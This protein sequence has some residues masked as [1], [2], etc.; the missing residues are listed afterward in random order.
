MKRHY[1]REISNRLKAMVND[2]RI[3]IHKKMFSRN[4]P[5]MK[6][7]GQIGLE[8]VYEQLG[9]DANLHSGF[10]DMNKLEIPK[11]IALGKK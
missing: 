3:I 8:E 11:R 4:D 10:L 6:R 2:R 5:L 9:F 7:V 1:H